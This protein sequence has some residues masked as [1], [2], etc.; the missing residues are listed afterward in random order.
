MLTR[1]IGV[2]ACA[3]VGALVFGALQS[4]YTL[5]LHAAGMPAAE[6]GAS[7]FLLAFQWV[8]RGAA[9]VAAV[10]CILMWSSRFVSGQARTG[11]G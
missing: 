11:A 4:H 10:T 7:A 5:Q 6:T 3:T 9:A 1:T 2:V 8:F